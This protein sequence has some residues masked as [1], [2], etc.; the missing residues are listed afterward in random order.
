MVF[1]AVATILGLLSARSVIQV[2][3]GLIPT[4]MKAGMPYLA[5]LAL[6][7]R[8]LAVATLIALATTLLF[9][10]T[11]TLRLWLSD[12]R[13]G[14]AE[15]GRASTGFLW[16][17]LGS[18]LIIAELA[19]AVVLLVGAG[20]LAT[21]LYRLLR[22]GLGFQPD[23]LA[24]LQVAAP[25]VTY[26][27]DAQEIALGRQIISRL[28]S[29]PGVRSVAIT[30]RLL[31]VS[32]N[33]NTDWIRFVGRPYNGQHNEVNERD[34]SAAYF[35]TLRARLLRGRYFT[36]AEDESKPNVA[37]IN[38][39]LARKYFGGQDPIG[40]EIG[41]TK[42]S[43]KSLKKIIGVVADV[44]EG[45]LDEDIWPTEYLP[46]NQS[47]E[48]DIGILAQTTQTPESMLATLEAV[49]HQVDPDI[50]VV[51]EMTMSERIDDSPTSYLHRSA[52]WVV[53][54]FAG[55]AL[56]LG[57]VGLYGVIAYTV[58]Q[59]TREIGIRLALGAQHRDVIRDVIRQ[60]G[61]LIGVGLAFGVTGALVLTHLMTSL[62]YGVKPADPAILAA[63]SAILT[64]AGLLACYIPARRAA[65]VDPTVALRYE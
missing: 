43:P 1:A 40:Q 11:P 28:E 21:S 27:K 24:A 6:N 52:V 58:N 53:G 3:M 62:L 30:S 19:V 59:R 4:D 38:E 10:L 57:V 49:I 65:R 37:I 18:N 13:D 17:R 8:V 14:L 16:R 48:T 5:G 36:D 33:G 54:G 23:H 2:L 56:L 60:G 25:P 42:L 44:R 41:D 29:L 51:H 15:G 64:G 12:L 20:L 7:I 50:G 61:L 63:V 9:A 32:F 47:P 39:A 35:T 22:V 55:V 46:F 31:P 34:V 26:G 45:P